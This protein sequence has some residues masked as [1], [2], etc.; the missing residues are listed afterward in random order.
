MANPYDAV[1]DS[2][3]TDNNSNPYD[4]IVGDYLRE[5]ARAIRQAGQATPQ[6]HA[7]TI[8]LSNRSGLPQELVQRNQPEVDALVKQR[9]NEQIL[10]DYPALGQFLINNNA[11][12]GL[13]QNDLAILGPLTKA[14]WAGQTLNADGKAQFFKARPTE[15]DFPITPD[16]GFMDSVKAMRDAQAQWDAGVNQH[17]DQMRYRTQNIPP[18]TTGENVDLGLQKAG[19]NL[20]VTGE[21]LGAVIDRSLASIG[22]RFLPEPWGGGSQPD[23]EGLAQRST[24]DL[25][26]AVVNQQLVAKDP[27]MEAFTAQLNKAADGSALS[28][29]YEAPHIL[30]Q[31]DDPVGLLTT[32][33]TENLVVAIPSFA[34]GGP[35]GQLLAA[36]VKTA[37]L[38]RV[39]SEVARRLVE[40]GLT[41]G[42]A[43]AAGNSFAVLMQSS[44]A[45]YAEATQKGMQG[46]EAVDYA[47]KKTL[48]EIPAN[49][50]AGALLAYKLGPNQ[51]S[52]VILQAT[53]QGTGGAL[54]A[55]TASVAV[56]E[57]PN[58]AEL[59]LEFWGEFV[60][61]PAEV[62]GLP[63]VAMVD[64]QRAAQREAQQKRD[65][66]QLTAMQAA[67][68]ADALKSAAA[69][70]AK[71]EAAQLGVEGKAAVAQV[72]KQSA[73]DS[74]VTIDAK[75]FEQ[76]IQGDPDFTLDEIVVTAPSLRNQYMTAIEVGG[77]LVIPTGEFLATFAQSPVLEPLLDHV[78]LNTS[79][80][81]LAEARKFAEEGD[82]QLREEVQKLV[83]GK[84]DG[85]LFNASRDRVKQLVSEQL[86]ATNRFTPAVNEIKAMLSASWYTTR[87][88]QQ[89]ITPEQMFERRPLRVAAEGVMGGVVY[90]QWAA[91][92]VGANQATID[93][94]GQAVVAQNA[95]GKPIHPTQDGV[96]N[97]WRWFNGDIQRTGLA[98][99]TRPGTDDRGTDRVDQ[100]DTARPFGLDES[101]RPR[102]FYYG[103]GDSFDAFDLDHPNRKDN[104]WLGR[105]VYL[106]NATQFAD[107][108]ANIK[109]GAAAPN[110]MPLY[111]AIHN[112]YIADLEFKRRMSKLS[113]G[114]IARVTEKLKALG[115][116][117]VVLEFSD[118]TQEVV[119]FEPTQVK[120]AIGNRGTFDGGDANILYQSAQQF[121]FDQTQTANF[122]QWSYNAPFISA[123]AAE[124][125]E[126]KT[127]AKVVVEAYHGTAR[128]DRVGVKF[129]KKR[130]TSGPMAFF[131]SSPELGSGY[132]TGKQDTSLAY[133]DQQYANWFKYK[134]KGV[135]TPMDITRA[136]YHLDAETKA[137]IRE[138]AP[139]LRHDDDG[140]VIA[141]PGNTSGNG[142]YDYNLQESAR[143]GYSR[144]GNPLDA[145][146]EDWLNSGT[147]FDQEEQFID[148]LRL[149]G[150]PTKDVHFDSPHV[151]YPFVYKT[152][153]RMQKPLV[154]SDIPQEVMDA[155]ASA[156]KR[157]RSRAATGGADMWDKNRRTL[158]E[159]YA[160][161][162]DPAN[163][164]V[165]FVWTSIPDK[166]TQVFKSLGYDG[167]IDESG[168]GGG[169]VHKVY[170][171]FEGTQV[172]SAI[173]NKGLFGDTGNILKQSA[174]TGYNQKR[175]DYTID[176]FGIP[177]APT[178]ADTVPAG[179]PARGR[180]ARS[181]S[182]DDAA[183]TYATRTEV[184]QENTRELGTRKVTTPENAAQAMA[185]L[186]RSAVERFDALITDKNGKP[187]AIVGAHKGAL[188]QA[189]VYPAT[190]V[191]EAFRINGAANIWFAHNH[192]SGLAELSRADRQLH[193]VLIEAF[194]GSGITPRGLFAVA[195]R[196]G[197]GRKWTFEPVGSRSSRDPDVYGVTTAP[198]QAV[199]VP[200]V[201]RVYA[202]E[203]KLGDNLTS[204]DAAKQAAGA[205]S[206]GQP[207]VVLLT[208]QNVPIA[209]VP[210]DPAEVGVLRQ[211]GRMDALYRALSV[212]NAG[213]A[214]IVNPSRAMSDAEVSN[215]AGLFNS[216]ETRV[217]DV[218]DPNHTGLS[219]AEQGKG[220]GNTFMQSDRGP[221]S[222][223][224]RLARVINQAPPKVFGSAAQVK[225]WL[226]GNAANLGVKK[227]EIQ[228]SGITDWLDIQKKVSKA[229]VLTYLDGNGVRVEPVVLGAVDEADVAAW[230]NDEGGAN[231]EVDFYDL[232]DT[233]R[234]NA[235]AQYKYEYEE[236]DAKFSSYRLPGGEDYREVLLTLPVKKYVD[237]GAS[238]AATMLFQRDMME[239]Y[240]GDSFP[241][242]YRSLSA[243]E[244]DKYA[245]YVRE[246][247][248]SAKTAAAIYDR[249]NNFRSTHWPGIDNVLAHLRVDTVQGA[250][251]NR[252]LRVIEIQSDWGQKGKKEG[253]AV[254][255]APITDADREAAKEYFDVRQGYWG[256]IGNE[257]RNAYVMDMRER[258]SKRRGEVPAAPFV[259]D[260]RAWTALVV[261]RAL[262]MAVQEGHDG[263]VFATGQQNADLYDLSKS[264][265]TVN[266]DPDNRRLIAT[267]DGQRLIDESPVPPE[268]LDDYI[269]KEVARK[270]LES[271]KNGA[272]NYQLSGLDLKVGGEGMRTF[273]D[274][275][276]PSVTKD[277]LK[278][279]G[280]GDVAI[281]EVAVEGAQ[282][283]GFLIPDTLR[284]TVAGGVPLFQGKGDRGTF[285]PD[286]NLITLLK[287]ADLSTFLHESGHFFFENDIT[288]ADE[289]L[290]KGDR[291]TGEQEIVDDVVTLLKWHG[292]QGGPRE[293]IAQWYGM[294]FEERRAYHERTA[295]SFERYLFE[296]RAPSIELQ[297]Y[298]QKFRAWL[299]NVYSA[300]KDFIARNPEAGKLNDEVRAVFDRM[301][302]TTDQ[303]RLAEQARNMMPVFA[304]A[305]QAGMTPAEF[306]AYQN[307][308]V[309]ASQVS[310][311]DLQAKGL[312]DMQWMH[313]ARSREIKRLKRESKD[314]RDEVRM[315]ARREIMSQPVYRAWQFLTNKITPDDK[316]TPAPLPKSNPKHLTP[317]VDNLLTAI[318]KLG[319]LNKAAVVA[320]WGSDPKSDPRSGV[321]GKPVWRVEGGLSIDSMA[322]QL[323][324]YGYL[325]LGS[326]GKW[327]LTDFEE[328][329]DRSLRGDD[330]Y[331]YAL[332]PRLMTGEGRAGEGLLVENMLAGRLDLFSLREIGI[333]QEIIDH[334]QAL[335]MV[336]NEGLHPDIV[337]AQFEF[338]TADGFASGDD[339]VRTLAAAETPYQAIEA[340]TDRKMLEQY[341]ELA[342]PEAIEKAADAAIH[343]E[344]RARF[345]ATELNAM[346]RALGKPRVLATAARQYADEVIA[347]LKIRDLR[348]SQYT[349]A[350]SRT[351]AASMKALSAGNRALAYAE[352]RNQVLNT[353]LAKAASDAQTEIEKGVRYLKKFDSPGTRKAI[354]SDYGDQIDALLERF[355]LRRVSD[356]AADR[357]ASLRAWVDS[358]RE[359]GFEP[360]IPERL[361]DESDRTP[362]RE[363]TVEAFRGLV[364]TIRQIEHLGRLKNRLLTAAKQREF[365]A[366]RDEMVA[367]IVMHGGKARPVQIEAEGRVRRWFDAFNAGN[368]K[369]SSLARQFDGL[370][371][372]GPWYEYL[373]RGMNTRGAWEASRLADAAHALNALYKPILAMKGGMR[374]DIRP[375]ANTAM[376]LS[377][378]GRI[379]LALNWGNFNNRQRI[380]NSDWGMGTL[381]E[382]QVVETISS[383]SREELEFVNAVWRLIDDFWPE[384]AEKEARV[385][386]K[387]P[388][389][390]DAVPFRLRLSD[391]TT[392]DMRGGYYPLKYDPAKSDKAAAFDAVEA[393]KD[394]MR[395][396]FTAA[397]TRR[398]HTKARKENVKQPVRLDLGV[399][400]EHL[401]QVVRDLAWHE[402]LIDANRML[403]DRHIAGAI[404]EHYGDAVLKTMR[405]ALIGIAGSDI[406]AQSAI[407]QALLRLRANVSAA[408]M[409]ISL[410]TAFL[411]PFGVAQS[412]VRI[413]PK[414]VMKGFARWGGDAARF[415]NTMAW[416]SEKSDFMRL[417]KQTF[418]R[419]LHEIQGRVSQGKGTARVIYEASLFMLM[420]KMQLIA[421]I[422]TWVGAYEK[423][424]AS[425][426]LDEAGAIAQADR[427][428][429]ESQGSGQSKDLT[430]FQRKHPMLTLFYSYFSATYNLMAESTSTTQ[431][432]NPLSVAG[433]MS[434]M[435][436]LAV[437]PA[438]G[439]ALILSALRGGDDDEDWA[440]KIAKWQTMYLLGLV[441]G[442][443]ELSGAVEGYDY[444]GPP[445]GRAV[446]D[447]GK[448]L[449]Q[450]G[451]G[452]ADEGLVIAT[453]RLVG[454]LFGIPA[455][456]LIR[457]WKGWNAWEDGDAA[458]A[459]V[460]LGPPPKD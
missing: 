232:S 242:V 103:T 96:R 92:A 333:P 263:I 362:Y 107:T 345:L 196:M 289:L 67:A 95:N 429:I 197:E 407:D 35:A 65:A 99:A 266:Y 5:Q 151:T 125:H 397:T 355:D 377:R 153:I 255:G 398:G 175:D 368:R 183:G 159:W 161:L 171:P 426:P 282:Q 218:I 73:P 78:R 301:L 181:L 40:K 281:G 260:T 244:I 19:A 308:D 38:K 388:E 89:G 39:E 321:F 137:T 229:D 110:V 14:P 63:F 448:L 384:I 173:G 136:W 152:Y 233:E 199:K 119:A 24:S 62:T 374:G 302:A 34:V 320:E 156:A 424:I 234:R 278:K 307:Q 343:N 104:G 434:D 217:L 418:N 291:T 140:K 344:A 214:I 189:A 356:K 459:A 126:F 280:A 211:G 319:G 3:L 162:T 179:R 372:K 323:S 168:K 167:I 203:D 154:T 149:A 195:G 83:A 79:K 88:A 313:N 7:Q 341:G 69:Q 268:K 300:I 312:R 387:A 23:I 135:R 414:W 366:A 66:Q 42:A 72:L 449:Q 444:A 401:H 412:M 112:P 274:Q 402:W 20:A 122:K 340:L 396:A 71:T 364:D 269:G 436:L 41:T 36:P 447:A 297:P 239:K 373:V 251:G 138:R 305:D 60:G 94:D 304:T 28:A 298:F 4:T 256:S 55:A 147:L 8:D 363:M 2:A 146:V 328:K 318:A 327:D 408:V 190:V 37:V 98:Q 131:T 315:E 432:K 113:P 261:K 158:R 141:D 443:R 386:G 191:A 385:Y 237:D 416:V 446:A 228:W 1:V 460:L 391:G 100:T 114:A 306:E 329:F 121:M 54:G 293:M 206:G 439:P 6:Q 207:G 286:L 411:Q 348:P 270:L 287:G 48:A 210:V 390:V 29:I 192:P 241:A 202:Q 331:S 273:Y 64:K 219:W 383:L 174:N 117:G 200:V 445:V 240:G 257:E 220:F 389:K 295:E 15:A 250:D 82:A 288:L 248:N 292:I 231:E 84:Q 427:A 212:S 128:P 124:T 133:E 32:F 10:R 187:L 430:E 395:G 413:G 145:L 369:L 428:V 339:L 157:D 223:Y 118:G 108:Y 371:D 246:D 347:R 456:Q 50:A 433:W 59:A 163:T 90:G 259:T 380:V 276:V 262:M 166:V 267:K 61:A 399:I 225:T 27:R 437:I 290:A 85:E 410:T 265:D 132:A 253:F 360:D 43:G 76:A 330:V 406:E 258:E 422:P 201:E 70:V 415:E 359:K 230:W 322:E 57:K 177:A 52:N 454:S 33:L 123:K 453:A 438:L 170:I 169:A 378:A 215:L 105:G 316:I 129:S 111:A 45:N 93:L 349:N 421:D 222:F 284:D 31:Q 221:V 285:A 208:T 224:S 139:T 252:Y 130:A 435:L 452:E 361:L 172:K 381:T 450:I 235:I 451:Q 442:L 30:A 249:Q 25:T 194:W 346:G 56:D 367:A 440:A 184:V 455:T 213:A 186:G 178:G 392:M 193:G 102:V 91:K 51:L 243:S 120:S 106:S 294:S 409:G 44:G 342:T 81:T 21:L 182:R 338:H 400:T 311:E 370:N 47:I 352:K 144:Q 353:S 11:T 458:P 26:S 303:I 350:A 160:E 309:Q 264:I 13:V 254:K 148:V 324:Q 87:A 115:H 185:Y 393:A 271:P 382:R 22:G 425:D 283:P 155:L 165:A 226:L 188:T 277:V 176:L 127:G 116:D 431:W 198:A 46:Q 310:I 75:T 351:G 16:R 394:A 332:D 357:R 150:F 336:S 404:R 109:R 326:N 142:S 164:S 236:D 101:G 80:M 358:Q 238:S 227:D 296:G 216:V 204:P 17:L 335:K 53:A 245:M 405:D 58:P 417:R 403:R 420:Q 68:D 334:L 441:P 77:D 376:S 365:K 97:F 180:A 9:T 317:E 375:I 49:A 86:N 247:R 379:A 74:T 12:A 314:R 143:R 275:I 279:L 423:A 419:E 272:G 457:S 18:N 134:P 209:F 299:T 337:A 325:E 205:L 354:D